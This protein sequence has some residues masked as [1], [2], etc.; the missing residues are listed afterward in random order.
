[1]EIKKDETMKKDLLHFCPFLLLFLATPLLAQDTEVRL[2]PSSE[3][4]VPELIQDQS[5]PNSSSQNTES[6]ETLPSGQMWTTRLSTGWWYISLG[7]YGSEATA[8]S[9]GENLLTTLGTQGGRRPALAYS[10]RTL[11]LGPLKPGEIFTF[12]NL[13]KKL[14]WKSVELYRP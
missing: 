11:Y 13:V 5:S 2:R 1:M 10:D 6:P 4:R 3:V 14:G 8:R 9:T 12:V 7:S